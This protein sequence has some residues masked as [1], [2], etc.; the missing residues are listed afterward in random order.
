MESKIKENKKPIY[1]KVITPDKEMLLLLTE[2]KGLLSSMDSHLKAM[3]YYQQ[4]SRG[5]EA[6]I[7]KH[8][9]QPFMQESLDLKKL[10]RE[11]LKKLGD[12]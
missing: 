5:F 1:D 4:P 7:E 12:K 6:G 10:V 3:A 9:A 8:I 2:I 11:E